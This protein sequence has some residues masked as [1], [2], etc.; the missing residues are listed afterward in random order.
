MKKTLSIPNIESI[1]EA[2]LFASGDALHID[3]LSE[4]TELEVE[5]LRGLIKNMMDKY[6][7]EKRGVKIIRL[8]DKYQMSTRGEFADYVQKIVEPKKKNPLS[9]AT[10]EV[11]AIIAYKQPITRASIEHVRGVNCDNS[12]SRLLELG[13]VEVVGRVDAPGRPSLL[14]TTDEFL[15]NFAISGLEELMPVDNF[16]IE[17]VEL[18]EQIT[19]SE[20]V[21]INEQ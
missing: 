17:E 2:C 5:E 13:L 12:V 8:G 6:N 20:Q 15:R 7:Y 4:I 9:K 14:G 10:M 1:I 16:V 3:K 11:L 18:N 19:I 21:E